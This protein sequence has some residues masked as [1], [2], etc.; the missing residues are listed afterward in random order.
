MKINEFFVQVLHVE[1][2]TNHRGYSYQNPQNTCK[3]YLVFPLDHFGDDPW[4]HFDDDPGD[5]FD[6]NPGDHCGK[7]P[8]DHFDGDPLDG[9]AR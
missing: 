4:D 2:H 8:L 3:L 1:N 9:V 7:N 5:H 6:D